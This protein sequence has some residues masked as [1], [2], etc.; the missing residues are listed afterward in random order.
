MIDN[1]YQ[2]LLSQ[3]QHLKLHLADLMK[4][5]QQPPRNRGT[6]MFKNYSYLP[7]LIGTAAGAELRPTGPPA[8][9]E[10]LGHTLLGDISHC[11]SF[12]PILACKLHRAHWPEF[13]SLILHLPLSR[14]K[15]VY[16]EGLAL[17]ISPPQGPPTPSTWQEPNG[18]PNEWTKQKC[19][20]SFH[21]LPV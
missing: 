6:R 4:A 12:P 2:H 5:S 18:Y 9:S 8:A 14:L 7:E 20:V 15:C 3:I 13:T 19:N 1:S 21:P 11:S 16:G 17:I 10:P